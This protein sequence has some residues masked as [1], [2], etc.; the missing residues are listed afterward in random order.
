M[1]RFF[2]LGALA[3]AVVATL[4]VARAGAILLG[5]GAPDG[6][7]HKG[8][9]YIVFYDAK[10][11][12]LWRCTG[13]LVSRRVV[14]TA[15]HC[16]GTYD[17]RTGV[18][19][20]ALAQ[21]WFDEQVHP[22]SYPSDGPLQ[23]PPV[24]CLR[25]KG[26][27][28]NGGDAR[29]LP[30]AHPDYVGSRAGGTSHDL[31]VVV[32][33]KQMSSRDV[34]GLAPVGSLA[35]TDPDDTSASMTIVGYGVQ[36]FAPSLDGDGAPVLTPAGDGQRMQGTIDFA[37]VEVD[38]VDGG[39]FAFADFSNAPP[40]AVACFGDS[41]GPVLN[42]AGDVTA[43]IALVDSAFCVGDA[44]HYRTDTLEAKKFLARVGVT[45]PGGS[46]VREVDNGHGRKHGYDFNGR[47]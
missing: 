31:G 2:A 28:C 15:G 16:A 3:A 41:G 43:V 37:G 13:T 17:N 14:L 45:V 19:T 23:D 18:H 24:S 1:K 4:F 21:I 26:Y 6:N 7:E 44:Y 38:G 29:G 30:I 22:G 10:M 9:G 20:P 12:P 33:S 34:T 27:P 36:A 42:P 39:E 35:A 8:V 46:P 5:T 40:G 11:I 25:Y 47:D 32:L